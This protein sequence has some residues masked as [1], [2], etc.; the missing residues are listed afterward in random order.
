L[1][2]GAPGGIAAEEPV[3]SI[4]AAPA[5][6]VASLF[7]RAGLLERLAGDSV[8]LDAAVGRFSRDLPGYVASLRTSIAEEDWTRMHE[9]AHTIKGAAATL[10]CERLRAAALTMEKD[11]AAGKSGMHDERLEWLEQTAEETIVAIQSAALK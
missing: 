10:N 3:P 8:I 4:A 11:P 5:H 1:P 9:I 6:P 2:A 7:D